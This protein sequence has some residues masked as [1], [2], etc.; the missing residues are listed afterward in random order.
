[1]TTAEVWLYFPT[2]EDVELAKK[3]AARHGLSLL[4][5]DR[6]ITSAIFAH[7]PET[8][9]MLVAEYAEC[10]RWYQDG[11]EGLP[12]CVRRFLDQDSTAATA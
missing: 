6:A 12:P 10:A 3:E 11:R 2:P 8:V 4:E 1:M 5:Y 7:D 9:E